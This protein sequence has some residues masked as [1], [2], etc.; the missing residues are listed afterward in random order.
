M[1]NELSLKALI[2]TIS[3][4]V[5]SGREASFTPEGTSMLPML[6]GGRDEIVLVRPRF[7]LKK[8][9]LPLYV[10][11]SG[12]VVLHRVVKVVRNGS[13]TEYQMRGDNTWENETGIRDE[14]IVAVVS[15]FC[16]AG[17]WHSVD[18]IGY[19]LYVRFWC[20]S[21]PVRRLMLRCRA[22]AH[23]ILFGPKR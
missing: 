9:E 12:A 20:L 8:Y 7:P 4:V 15:R 2:P 1:Q 22:L 18:S 19:R 14:N 6:T 3:E 5:Q 17:K 13:E 11:K 10:R 23:R 16:R 21:Y